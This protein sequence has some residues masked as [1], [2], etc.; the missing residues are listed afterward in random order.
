MQNKIC[1][2]LQSPV[3]FSVVFGDILFGNLSLTKSI[4]LAMF[5]IVFLCKLSGLTLRTSYAGSG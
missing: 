3:H 5:K 2:T 1:Y 4:N